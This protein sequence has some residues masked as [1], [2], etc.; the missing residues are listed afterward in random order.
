MAK[1]RA[2]GR[3]VRVG[4]AVQRQIACIS[5][6]KDRRIT[7]PVQEGTV[8]WVHPEG[9]FHVV[10]FSFRFGRIRESYAGVRA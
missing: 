4:E 1:S 5:E 10:E 6:M 3:R 7:R 2:P 8:I 9:R